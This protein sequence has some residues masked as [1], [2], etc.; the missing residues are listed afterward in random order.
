MKEL[1]LNIDIAGV[2]FKNPIIAASGTYGFGL[3]YER[4]MDLNQLGGIAVTGLTLEPR[5]GNPPPRIAETPSGI[6]NSV[7][8]Q[9]PGIDLFLE[10]YL[11]ILKEYKTVI[12]A[13]INGNTPGEYSELASRLADSSVDMVEL[14]LSC[15]N[16]REGGIAFGTDPKTVYAIT[17]EV[18]QRVRHPL[19]VKLTPNVTDITQIAL[20]AQEGGGN[21]ISLVNTFLGMAIDAKTRKPILANITGGLSGPAIKPLALR[22]VWQV[23]GAVKIPVIGMGGIMSGEDTAEFLLAGATAAAVGTANLVSPNAMME[24]LDGLKA[25]MTENGVPRIKEL[26]GSLRYSV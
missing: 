9:N 21:A 2:H 5:K 26:I 23:S 19:I 12:I 22:M 20:A 15:P 16:V 11:P 17:K 1:D 14:N 6:L 10:K 7:G 3:E 13:N 4:Y 24:I 25:Y 18:K 8:L